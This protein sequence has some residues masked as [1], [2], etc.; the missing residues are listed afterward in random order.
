VAD[1]LRLRISLMIAFDQILQS[2]GLVAMRLFSVEG[3]VLLFAGVLLGVVMGAIPG[4]GAMT[5]LALLLPFTYGWNPLDAMILLSAVCGSVTVGGAVAAILI[6][7][8]GTDSNIATTLDGY[9]M[10]KQGRAVEALA[11]AALASLGGSLVGLLLFLPLI[12]VMGTVSLAFGPPEVFWLGIFTLVML[13]TVTGGSFIMNLLIGALAF[14]LSTHGMGPIAG[15]PRFAFGLTYLW[16]GIPL[17]PAMVGTFAFSEMIKVMAHEQ[18]MDREKLEVKGS[19]WRAVRNVTDN[20]LLFLK[21]S[22]LGYIIGVIPG[23][24]GTVANY[25][26]YGQAVQSAKNPETFGKGDVRGVVGPES[27]N[28]AKDVGQ[29]VP[30][31]SLGIPG[32]GTMAVFL[33]ALTLHG[34]NPGPFLIRDHLDVVT[35][36]T[37]TLALAFSISCLGVFFGGKYLSRVLEVDNVIV[38]VTVVTVCFVA[39]YFIRF[40][41]FDCLVMLA[42]GVLGYV[43]DKLKGSRILLAL[44][45]IL[46]PIIEHNFILALQISVGDYSYFFKPISLFILVLTLMSFLW[47]L[48]RQRRSRRVV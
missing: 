28:N 40:Q 17:V 9:P 38:S 15:V 41:I 30:T 32:S 23:V 14:V 35:M 29:L 13:S 10:A 2:F 26:A 21:S 36:I 19:K 27:A 46:G 11:T 1:S 18:G 7:T 16:G 4:L 8:P 24:G 34:L 33:G 12:P 47:P 42:F 25:L 45:L 37:F 43:V 39:A 22:I 31:L 3:I 48:I 6:N 5:T 44:P 20:L